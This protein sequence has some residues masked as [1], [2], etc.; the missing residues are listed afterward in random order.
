M[1]ACYQAHRKHTLLSDCV[2]S[3]RASKLFVERGEAIGDVIRSLIL[4][5]EDEDARRIR[6]S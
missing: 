6:L 1:E 5:L 2:S 3:L 4:L